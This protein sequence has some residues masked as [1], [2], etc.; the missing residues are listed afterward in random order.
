MKRLRFYSSVA[1]ASFL[2][3]LKLFFKLKLLF[4]L[5]ALVFLSQVASFLLVFLGVGSPEGTEKLL[6]LMV[7]AIVFYDLD[8]IRSFYGVKTPSC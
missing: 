2:S 7:M 1:S 6:T 4:G 3:F 5:K 8:L